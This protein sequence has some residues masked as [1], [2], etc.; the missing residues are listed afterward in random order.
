MNI[1]NERY[2]FTLEELDHILEREKKIVIYG[3]GDYGKRIADY[4]ISVSEQSKIESFWIT[5]K[6]SESHYRGIRIVESEAAHLSED[7]DSLVLIAVSSMYLNEIAAVVQQYGRR[8]CCITLDLYSELGR[9]SILDLYSDKIVSFK[10]LDFLVAGFA[11]CGTTSLYKA[12]LNIDDIYLSEKK[13]SH[14]FRWFDK[15]ADPME[16]LIEQYFYHIQAG[17][18]VG[19][20][21]PSFDVEAEQI[22]HFFGSQVKILFLVRN[23]VDAEFSY[24]KM[25][26]RSGGARL[27]SD[28]YKQSGGVYGENTFERFCEQYR[29]QKVIDKYKYVDSIECFLKYYPAGQIKIAV[30]E[31]MVRNPQKVINDILQFIGSSCEYTQDALPRENEGNYVMA[32]IDG[33]RA[34]ESWGKMSWEYS[35]IN[36]MSDK[37]RRDIFHVLDKIKEQYNCAEK[38]YDLKISEQTR[39]KMELYYS[40]SVR[41]LEKMMERDLSDIWF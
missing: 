33:L 31:E 38:V 18:I 4:I 40:D 7:Q 14:F 26:S 28:A 16:R 5:H 6:E 24:F 8:Y 21:E 35:D 27:L 9:R 34:A 41:K 15:V 19:M 10:K 11:K 25:I 30:F 22:A 1:E 32:D 13:E 39:S 36:G 3:A 12:L 17:Q 29:L 37:K 20:I 2:L 23:P